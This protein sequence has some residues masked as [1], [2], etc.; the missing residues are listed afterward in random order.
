MKTSGVLVD[1]NWLGGSETIPVK[2]KFT[3]ELFG[4]VTAASRAQVSLAAAQAAR[5]QRDH[6]LEPY[7]RFEILS[8]ASELIR[9]HAS[10]FVETIVAESGFTVGDAEAEVSRAASTLLLSGEEAKRLVGEMVPLAGSSEGTNRIGFTFHRPIGV[11]CAITPF[12]SP[13][14]TVAHKLGPAIAAGNSVLLKPATVTPFTAAKLCEVLIEAGLPAGFISLLNGSGGTVGKW[15]VGEE[16]VGFFTFTG[17]TE[18]GRTIQE[19]AGLRRT[20]LELG[21]ISSTIVCADAR[22]EHVIPRSIEAAFRK[23]GQVCT[24]VQR[25]YVDVA[26]LDD[27][28]DALVKD[29][30]QRQV[31]D[32]SDPATFVGPLISLDEAKRVES[33]IEA[34]VRGGAHLLCG[35][36]RV[37]SVVDPALLLGVRHDMAVM[38]QEVFGPVM[39]IVPFD[40]LDE[41]IDQVNATPYGLAAGIFTSDID[42]AFRAAHRLRMGSV[43]INQ[44]SSSRIDLMPYGGVKESGFGHEGPKYAVREMSEERLITFSLD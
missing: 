38:C 39:S 18:V 36:T 27:L 10:D 12:N 17:S 30:E 20:Q 13:L 14:N 9:V 11:V 4:E 21:S 16:E 37:G 7:Q 25:L 24:S 23:A 15:L 2:N 34:A 35:G 42:L 8:R 41:A 31:G 29:L 43:H 1:G 5:V 33:W 32:P 6:P 26:I 3:G 44:T 22:L 40:V 19:S 28:V